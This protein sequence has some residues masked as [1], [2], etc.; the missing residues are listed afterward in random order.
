MLGTKSVLSSIGSL[1]DIV[2]VGGWYNTYKNIIQELL[3]R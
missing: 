1:D 3:N 2:L